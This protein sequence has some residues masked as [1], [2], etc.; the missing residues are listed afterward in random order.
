MRICF[1]SHCRTLAL[2]AEH[3]NDNARLRSEYNSL[4]EER[5]KLFKVGKIKICFNIK[6]MI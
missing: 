4:L 5:S 1:P 6:V 3:F 2:E